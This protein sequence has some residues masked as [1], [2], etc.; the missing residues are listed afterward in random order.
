[1]ST[2]YLRNLNFRANDLGRESTLLLT[3]GSNMDGIYRDYF[4]VVW[5]V[6]TFGAQGQFMVSAKYTNQLVFTKPQVQNLQIVGSAATVKIDYGQQTTLTQAGGGYCFGAPEAG[7]DDYIKALNNT[8]KNEA[9]AI[10]FAN[11]D[12]MSTPT[13]YF[14]D[15]GN[16]SNITAQFTPK[17]RAY[18]TTYYQEGEILRAEIQ[19]PVIWERDLADL[20]ESTT[21]NL[22]MDAN[23][24][25]YAITQV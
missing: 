21:W 13:L 8:G 9:M 23:T 7:A 10:G 6:T 18:I 20:D 1:M 12:Y 16:N 24:G 25:N 2:I 17:L 22:T 5:R 15:I 3:F 4:P 11:D 14:G 19:A